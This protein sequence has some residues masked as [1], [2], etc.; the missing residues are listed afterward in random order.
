MTPIFFLRKKNSVNG[1][2]I[3]TIQ[4]TVATIMV[5]RVTI[6]TICFELALVVGLVPLDEGE[7][8]ARPVGDA[9]L[10]VLVMTVADPPDNVVE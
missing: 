1:W 10:I 5:T 9:D 3:Y 2:T 8:E 7:P 4:A 6:D